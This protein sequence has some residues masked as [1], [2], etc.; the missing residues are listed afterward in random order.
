MTSIQKTRFLALFTGITL[1]FVAVFLI[2]THYTHVRSLIILGSALT[3]ISLYSVMRALAGP[4]A[5]HQSLRLGKILLALPVCIF[6]I[7][8]FL[9]AWPATLPYAVWVILLGLLLFFTVSR[10]YVKKMEG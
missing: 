6:G 8:T 10:P 1:L 3:I 5:S 7:G 9:A 2:L 4:I